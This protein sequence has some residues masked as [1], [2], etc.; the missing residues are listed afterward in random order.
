[1]NWS[2]LDAFF[3]TARKA[4]K[5]I[6]GRHSIRKPTEQSICSKE[7]LSMQKVM[8]KIVIYAI[9]VCRNGT[10]RL[11]GLQICCVPNLHNVTEL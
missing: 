1:M 9:E 5:C 7:Q 8:Y 10:L 2:F 11:W 4:K 3:C 6:H